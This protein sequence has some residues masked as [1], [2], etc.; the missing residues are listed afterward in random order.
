MN[1]KETLKEI[2]KETFKFRE[3]VYKEMRKDFEVV[4]LFHVKTG[5]YTK[6]V[7]AFYHPAICELQFQLP[8]EEGYS[9]IYHLTGNFDATDLDIE[10]CYLFIADDENEEIIAAYFP[11]KMY[12]TYN[13]EL[14]KTC[15]LEFKLPQ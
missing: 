4:F 1:V 3:E 8:R 5:A 14:K 13:D 11:S 6:K 10:K 7:K 9:D 2:H 12:Y 15:F